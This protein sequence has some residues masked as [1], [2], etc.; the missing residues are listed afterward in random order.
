MCMRK[1]Y[2]KL[3]ALSLMLAVSVTMVVAV[4]YAWVVM[5]TNPEVSG[6]QVT[7]GGGKTILVAADLTREVDGAVYHYPDQ[8]DDK[9]HF[10]QHE[11]YAFLQ[12]VASLMPVSTAD[13]IHWFLPEYYDATDPQV[14]SGR[15]PVGQ[16]K[17]I[18]E[19]TMEATLGHANLTD[20]D[21]DS[22]ID[23]SYVYL[24][25]WVVSPGTDCTLRVSVPTVEGD[26]SGGSFV[27]EQ[28]QPEKTADG[29]RLVQQDSQAAA[30]FRVGFLTNTTTV[31]DDSMVHYLSSPGY[32]PQ[33]RSLRGLYQE[34]GMMQGDWTDQRF[35]IYEPN[36]DYHP[37]IEGKDGT[38]LATK[39][40]GLVDG[41]PAE[42]SVLKQV[43]VQRKSG[44]STQDNGETV[45]E[46]IYQSAIIGKDQMNSQELREYFYDTYLQGLVEHFVDKGTFVKQSEFL[47]DGMDMDMAPTAGA[48]DDVYIVKLERDIP[49]RIRMFVWLE[50]QDADCTNITQAA[51]LI[52]NL[53]F[54]GST[55][56]ETAGD[57]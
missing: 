13:G 4:S 6:L 20:V 2:L 40:V 48:T 39:P 12:D 15:I 5:S 10:G 32:D 21:E 24:D 9:L 34:P 37:G 47:F 33:Y 38:Y 51:S 25:F 26:N 17:D 45:L 31:L 11:S 52:L 50:G 1:I 56:G 44:W 16:I 30:M 54:A 35:T 46:Q 53:E 41:Q 55:A 19:F 8:F 42:V 18:T 14:Q 3:I 57:Q 22:L 27:L 28:M 23:G 7:I 43:T 36:A 49:Q 29:T